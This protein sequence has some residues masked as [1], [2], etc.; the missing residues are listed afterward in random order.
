MHKPYVLSD[1]SDFKD[2]L[3]ALDNGGMGFIA[4][5]DVDGLLRGIVTDGDVRRAVLNDN[6]NIDA[7]VNTCPH[8]MLEGT[9]QREI[10]AKLKEIQRR[11]IPLVDENGRFQDVFCLEDVEMITKE[12]PVVI[13]AGGLGSRL[14]EL[15]KEIP[16]P[17]LHVGEK[18]MLQ[19]LIEMFG[20]H[21]YY[22][23][24]LCV[25]YKKEVIK[26][27]FG[28]GRA[29]GVKIEY[30]EEDRK[31]GTAG[32]LSLI[33]HRP[34]MPFFVINADILTTIDFD[35]LMSFHQDHSSVATMC[36]RTYSH[37]IPYGVIRTDE[38]GDILSLEE[39]PVESFRINAGIYILDPIVLDFVP[40]SVFFDMPSL[41]SEIISQGHKA[42]VYDMSDYWLDIGRVDDFEKAKIDMS[43]YL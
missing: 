7:V 20:D 9:P 25:N 22:H 27:Y 15:T 35:N 23:F 32:A 30:I 40:A 5:T 28:T 43:V 8:V 31:L 38:M 19:H 21:G 29:I 41:F 2:I 12:N 14:G 33:K 17:M 11:S 16:K 3:K 37:E 26:E 1:S 39:K 34:N 6:L 24:V 36:V 13:M 18:P 4:L 42:S 10:I